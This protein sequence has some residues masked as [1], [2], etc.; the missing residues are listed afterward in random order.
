[1]NILAIDQGTSATKALLI[2]P[3]H[4][5]LSRAEVPV[6]TTAVDG[7]GVEADPEELWRSVVSAGALIW[8]TYELIVLIGPSAFRDAQ[9]Y[10]L[11][12]LGVGLVFYA[13]QWLTEPAAMR[14]EV[15]AHGVD[16]LVDAG[17]GGSAGGPPA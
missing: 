3:G 8:L 10:V 4:E 1:M 13:V 15:G 6:R 14:T 2:G 7:D 17:T 5:V 9:Y 12:A 16:A 11:G